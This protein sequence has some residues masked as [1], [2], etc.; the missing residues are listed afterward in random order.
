MRP[1]RLAAVRADPRIW[2]FVGTGVW[3]GIAILSLNAALE[4]GPLSIVVPLASC[5]P[6]FVLLLGALV[7]RERN[8]TRRVALAVL[9][10]VLGVTLVSYSR[11]A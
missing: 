2:W 10:V 9:V 8:I 7:F 3:F 1:H 5:E 4:Y 11:Y 6:L